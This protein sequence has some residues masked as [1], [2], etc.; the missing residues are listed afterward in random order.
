MVKSD[1]SDHV[2]FF[3]NGE[4]VF[5]IY[6]PLFLVHP[7]I[8]KTRGKST[9]KKRKKKLFGRIEH[10]LVDHVASGCGKSCTLCLLLNVCQEGEASTADTRDMAEHLLQFN[11]LRVHEKCIWYLCGTEFLALA[12]VHTRVCNVSK[13][14]Q[15]EHEARGEA[16]RV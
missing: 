8:M 9:L 16:V 1:G 5:W 7:G 11:L 4:G 6:P 3:G 14:D 15:L 2:I 12:A 10:V 13:P